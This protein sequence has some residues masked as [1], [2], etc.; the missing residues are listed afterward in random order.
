MPL[1]VDDLHVFT[2][3]ATERSVSRAAAKLHM[4]QQSVSE[5]IRSLERLIGEELFTRSPRGMEPTRAGYRL[6]PYAEQ[7]VNLLDEAFH[8]ARANGDTETLRI[9]VH[10]SSAPAVVPFLERSLARFEV[11]FTFHDGSVDEIVTAVAHGSADIAVGPVRQHPPHVAVQP[12]AM[13]PLVCVTAP[14]NPLAA[15]PKIRLADLTGYR[16]AV[17]IWGEGDEQFTELLLSQPQVAG[18]SVDDGLDELLFDAGS[19][20]GDA[21]GGQGPPPDRDGKG[22]RDPGR[23]TICARSMVAEELA[24][25]R[26]VELVISDLP[27]WAL[28]LHVVYRHADAERGPIGALRDALARSGPPVA[29]SDPLDPTG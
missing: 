13:D 20:P 10:A 26:L 29:W 16:V 3:V 8:I 19:R 9:E 11:Q 24:D 22:L 18:A 5:R 15:R 12:F 6:L 1:K 27:D 7:C 21:P 23:A 14:D 17:N 28:Q 25:G 2:L 4:A